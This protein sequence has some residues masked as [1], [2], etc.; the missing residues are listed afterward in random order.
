MS[1]IKIGKIIVLVTASA[2]VI[3]FGG[4][5]YFTLISP[6]GELAEAP[7]WALLQGIELTHRTDADTNSPTLLFNARG[8][9]YVVLGLP[10]DNAR[11][12][13]AWLILND[14]APLSGIYILLPHDGIRVSC[15]YVS[16][17]P[18][19]VSIKPEV[20]AFLKKQCSG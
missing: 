11:F 5:V 4:L 9:G 2:I 19:K 16:E 12:P 8:S 15:S 3:A 18:S 7:E 14:T 20:L 10:S 6:R 13:K 17:L 1:R